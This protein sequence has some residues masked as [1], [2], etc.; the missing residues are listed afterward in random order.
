M[1]GRQTHINRLHV[2]FFT[3]KGIIN[4]LFGDKVELF[5]EL[6]AT[7]VKNTCN[8]T[9]MLIRLKESI[10]V[11]TGRVFLLFSHF[12]ELYIELYCE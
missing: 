12:V 6:Y 5:I 9:S 8:C 1:S 4:T 10:R 7:F 3:G 11:Q 2:S